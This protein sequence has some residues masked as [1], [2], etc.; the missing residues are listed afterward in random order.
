MKKEE[1]DRIENIEKH[2]FEIEERLAEVEEAL[3]NLISI[4]QTIFNTDTTTP[5]N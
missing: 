1:L 5:K 2:L 4:I 3:D